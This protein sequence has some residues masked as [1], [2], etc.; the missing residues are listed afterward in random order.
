MAGQQV[1]TQLSQ[2]QGADPQAINGM[3]KQ[4]KSIL[5]ALYPRTAFSIPDVAKNLAKSQ[6]YI[7][8]AIKASEEAASTSQA[9][10]PIANNA[11]IPNPTGGGGPSD[12]MGLQQFASGGGA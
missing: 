12:A 7:D 8:A 5:V 6:Q 2:L 10:T 1:S 3:L 11:S 9:V 4:V